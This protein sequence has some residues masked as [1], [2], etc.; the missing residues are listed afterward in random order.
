MRILTSQLADILFESIILNEANS[1]FSQSLHFATAAAYECWP[2]TRLSTS[3][4]GM[5]E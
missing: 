4:R 2:E 5:P 1:I 3:P